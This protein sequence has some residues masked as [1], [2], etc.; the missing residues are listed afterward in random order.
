[1]SKFS[2]CRNFLHEIL[3]IERKNVTI[4]FNEIL[5]MDD[6]SY[7]ILSH[8]HYFIE[9]NILWHKNIPPPPFARTVSRNYCAFVWFI[10]DYPCLILFKLRDWIFV[11][12]SWS[13][14]WLNSAIMPTQSGSAQHAMLSTYRSSNNPKASIFW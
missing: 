13:H 11:I 9:D 2:I 5:S 1:M 8:G 4:K 10:K 12:S 3:S 7:Q 6:I 14:I